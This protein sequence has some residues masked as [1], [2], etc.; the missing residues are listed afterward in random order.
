M[1][2]CQISCQLIV[3]EMRWLMSLQK[4]IVLQKA[5]KLRE[6]NFKL[7]HGIQPCN[8]NLR[9]WGIKISNECDVCG[10]PQ[11]NRTFKLFSCDYVRPLWRVVQSV[12]DIIISFESILGVDNIVT[13]VSFLIYKEWL[14]LSLEN[15]SRRSINTL[16]YFRNELSTRMTIYDL[17]KKLSVK[18]IVNIEA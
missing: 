9:K 16:Q 12:F 17:S 7:F 13:L 5:I 11:N 8:V 2:L 14:V 3:I 1:S 10:M 4:K 6:F 18:E 15:K